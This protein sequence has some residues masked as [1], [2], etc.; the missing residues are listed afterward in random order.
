MILRKRGESE[1]EIP[2]IFDKLVQTGWALVNKFRT[3]KSS[4]INLI[5][6]TGSVKILINWHDFGDFESFKQS[7]CFP[8]TNFNK[9]RRFKKYCS[10]KKILVKSF[11]VEVLSSYE[12]ATGDKRH[13]RSSHRSRRLY[14]SN[15]WEY[16]NVTCTTLTFT[17]QDLA[18]SLICWRIPSVLDTFSASLPPPVFFATCLWHRL[19]LYS[20]GYLQ[21]DCVTSPKE[22]GILSQRW[23]IFSVKEPLL[24]VLCE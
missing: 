20:S 4:T 12:K 18:E 5:T 24:I 13:L 14:I 15:A 23:C 1:R 7:L 6:V 22:R 2:Q 19:S 21:E 8:T 3:D 17:S 9:L 16:V 10:H 11:F